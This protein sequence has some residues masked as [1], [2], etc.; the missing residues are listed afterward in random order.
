MSLAIT[1]ICDADI[2]AVVDLWTRAGIARPWN[3][4]VKDIA[5]A[6]AAP[7]ATVLVGKSEDAV[8]A[9]AMVGEDG[10][11]GWVYYVAIAPEQQGKGLG[12]AIMQAAE[13]WL[14]ARGIWKMQL[15]VRGDNAQARGFYENLG[16]VMNDTVMFQKMID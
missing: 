2:P 8:T 11:R 3:D 6:R 1:E 12:R 16:F 7:H 5:F 13:G 14:K 10:H 9:S 4:P 15:L